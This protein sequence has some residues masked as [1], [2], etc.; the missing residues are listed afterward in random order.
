MLLAKQTTKKIRAVQ[1]NYFILTRRHYV[2]Q[3]LHKIFK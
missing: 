2:P 1:M 3:N